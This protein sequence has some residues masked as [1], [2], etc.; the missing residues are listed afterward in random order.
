MHAS[1]A[2]LV[3]TGVPGLD[4]I[5]RGGLPRKR[6][7][8][9]QGAPGVG[10]TTVG[11]QL[12]LEGLRHGEGGLYVTL[13]ETEDEL[14]AVATSHGWDLTGIT[15]HQLSTPEELL[16][17]QRA[18]TIFHTAEVEL[19]ETV[20]RVMNLVERTKPARIVIDS[21]SEVRLLAGDSLRYRRQ[22]L[23]LKQQFAGRNSTVLFLDDGT[24]EQGDLQIQSIAHGVIALDKVV[25]EYGAV[26]RRLEVVKLRGVDFHSGK[27]DF[28]IDET[29]VRVFP[30]LVIP[31]EQEK[32]EHQLV[33]S[34]ISGL[35]ALVG[36]GLERG[37]SVV[38]VGPAGTGKSSVATL[39]AEA[40]ARRNERAVFYTFD[41][42]LATF[43][44]RASGMGMALDGSGSGPLVVRRIEPGELSPGAFADEVQRSVENDGTRLIVIDSLNSYLLAMPNQD[45]LLLHIHELLTY[46]GKRGVLTVLVVAQHGLIQGM[47]APVDMTYLADTVVLF[48]FFEA[49][50][51]VYK[52][53]SVMK[54]RIG[55]QE[56][57]IRQYDIDK[58]GIRVGPPLAEFR[59]VLTGVPEYVG[60]KAGL[61]S[62][63]R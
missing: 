29:G 40:A 13:S 2:S 49:K 22:I 58:E 56:T 3:S 15:L 62:G 44:S 63:K 12:L 31:P 1:P 52:A 51:Q 11:L 16:D 61:S 20:S 19:N 39:Y 9:L 27:H 48:R 36:G 35:D 8:L 32:A 14:R 6:I 34:G 37:T 24:S 30:R 54:K 57:T 28:N 60:P 53:I 41:E 38:L 43:Y 25:P 45:L 46:L 23:S 7:Y 55:G 33:S 59:G 5:L 17:Q 26:R 21:L 47:Q 18:S 10:K 4:A 42:S 50:G